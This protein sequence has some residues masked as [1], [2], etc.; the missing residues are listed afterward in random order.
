[1]GTTSETTTWTRADARRA[2]T[3]LETPREAELVGQWRGALAGTPWLRRFAEA[4]ALVTPFRGWCGK[5]FPGDGTVV[6]RVLRSGSEV[7]GVVG[8]VAVGPSQLDGRPA[9]A[10]T[11]RRTALPPARWMR[12]EVRWLH[13]GTAALGMLFLPVGGRVALGPFP[14]LLDRRVEAPAE[15]QEG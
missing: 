10:V 9:L 7:P 5:Q 13:E 6:N 3:D 4:C 14:F 2:F 15:T 12:G 11:Y 8:V 1:M